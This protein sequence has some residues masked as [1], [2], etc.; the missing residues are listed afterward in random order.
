MSESDKLACFMQGLKPL[1]KVELIIKEVK[2]LNQAILLATEIEHARYEGNNSNNSVAKVNY[3]TTK[4]KF[5][6]FGKSNKQG[7]SISKTDNIFCYTCKN[8]GHYSS[9]C[10]NKTKTN[11]YKNFA[12]PANNANINNNA[13]TF[14]NL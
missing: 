9:N 10:P 6:A 13:N 5:N 3:S 11:K 7:S 1:T 2:T 4:N 8:K 14:A 12:K